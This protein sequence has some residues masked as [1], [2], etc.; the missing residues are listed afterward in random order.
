[1]P[2]SRDALT[3]T[4]KLTLRLFDFETMTPTPVSCLL[5]ALETLLAAEIPILNGRLQV[6][7]AAIS[8]LSVG[9]NNQFALLYV[10]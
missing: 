6:S 9:G 2:Q 1:M 8:N 3:E 7:R 5:L 4:L 10:C